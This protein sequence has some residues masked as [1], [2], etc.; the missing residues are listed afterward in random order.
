[1][2]TERILSAG[3]AVVV[4][5]AVGLSAST[6]AASMSTD[7]ADAVDVQWE[8]LPLGE[9]SQ[10]EIQAAAQEVD[11]RY[12]EG[13]SGDTESQGNGGG[14]A[15]QPDAKAG[16]GPQ[17]QQE[18]GGAGDQESRDE[19]AGEGE[20]RADS[21]GEQDDEPAGESASNSDSGLAPVGWPLSLLLWLGLVL[22]VVILAYRYRE[23]LRRAVWGDPT[24]PA[25]D[26]L[27][28]VPQ[29]DVERAWVE[30]VERA[31]VDRPR[32]HTPRDCA[33]RAVERGFD[34]GQVD[35]L[36]RTFEDVR[37]GTQPP[38]DEQARLARETLASL[39]G[40]RA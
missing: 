23:R 14:D 40:E 37:Y 36:R 12:R 38:S 39:D 31:G 34:P 15:K 10:G 19:R 20:R 24:D 35:R 21:A 4:I 30:L 26:P 5:A 13:G 3:M 17:D 18:S 2:N 25:A 32:T 28:P 8:L 27:A 11:E 33:R 16:D 9:D 29:N 1:M 6:L 7:P 22:A